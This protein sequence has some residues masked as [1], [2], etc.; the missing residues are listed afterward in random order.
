ME[1][2]THELIASSDELLWKQGCEALS[3]EHTDSACI[4]LIGLLGDKIWRKRE[5][6]AKF[7]IEWGPEVVPNL[8]KSLDETLPDHFYWSLF[9]L[10]HFDIPIGREKIL[11]NL[12]SPKAE[13]R[14]YA[15]RALSVCA[16]LQNAR[17]LYPLLS[18]RN[19]TIRKL[20][21]E[22]LFSF[23]KVILED[24]RQILL[25]NKDEPSHSV[26][27]LFAKLGQEKV[28]PE[29]IK[30]YQEGSFSM[31]YSVVSA[32]SEVELG[33]S[34]DFI[35]QSLSDSSWV[36]RKK[37]AEVLIQMGTR[38]FDRLSAW[39]GQGD[40]IM[41]RQI[42]DIIVSLL[43]ERALPL[44]QRLLGS[45][46]QEYRILAVESLSKLPGDSA[47]RLL[48]KSMNDQHRIVADYA[49]ECLAKKSNLNLD[50]LV[51]HLSTE[52]ENLRFLI[53]KTIGTIGGL[54]LNPIIQ[55]LENG[56]KDERMFLLG[57]LQRISPSEKLIDALIKM[58]GDSSWPIRSASA[59]CLKGYGE[60][61]VPGIVRV[62]NHESDDVQY[63][64]K[65]VLFSMGNVAVDS[66]TQILEHGSDPSLVPHLISALLSVDHPEAV[67]VVLR[68][69]QN[70]DDNRILFIIDG[71]QEITSREVINNILN[72]INHPDQR[73]VQWLS[74][75]LRK[76]KKPA[77][78]KIVLLGFGHSE[79]RCRLFV[80]DSVNYWEALTEPELKTIS[81]QLD[82]ERN[83]QNVIGLFRALGN[84]PVPNVIE[85]IKN[86][87]KSC[88]PNL[89][90]DLMVLL[91]ETERSQFFQ[92]LIETLRAR[93]EVIQPEDVDRVGKILG[94]LYKSKP[95]G[96]LQGL[97]S[98][99]MAYRL[100]S[101]VALEQIQGKRIA[102]ALMDSL[103]MNDDPTIINRA[104]KILAGY[105]FSED[106]RVK[107]AVTD[108]FLNLGK[109]IIDP[110]IEFARD[111][112]N[113]VDRKS[114]ID[115]IE[116]VGGVVDPQ[117][118]T[119]GE[120]KVVLSDSRL[121]EVLEKRKKALNELEKYDEIIRVS[122]TQD[123]T[124]MFTDVKGYTAFSSKA[125][126]SDVMIMLKQHDEILL[127]IITKHEGQVLKKIGDAF[128]VIFEK[129]H[130]SILS[131]IE[132]QRELKKY[133][134]DAP[135][136]RKLGVRVAINTGSVI[137]REGD[138]FG[139]AVNVT[140]RLEG[141]ADAEEIVISESTFLQVDQ[142]IFEITSFGEHK[143]KG[144]EKPVKAFKVAW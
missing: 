27:A 2:S 111:L 76:V 64:A 98:P 41:K 63:W 107:G 97:S 96:I 133:N 14:A 67:P 46:D 78:R 112:E 38:I 62:L 92:M 9:V 110:L 4:A 139:D 29:L 138:I 74:H 94:L 132:I 11:Q 19:W 8:V 22:K 114:L 15:I 34:V 115:L 129:P 128:L 85:A 45:P 17:V 61:A 32:L 137:R 48:I 84:Y 10:G 3:V 26:V 66:L 75:L 130:K 16:S 95:E 13:I 28:L 142:K 140:S 100:C 79:E 70:N 24:L 101:V 141:V 7:L 31:R 88:E 102:F 23:G 77:L 5:F 135:D 93:S 99:T 57:V 59:A 90:L 87:L 121:D 58:L 50:L 71:I 131:A 33:E 52:D 105:F 81:R 126:L 65:R 30:L 120:R 55:I 56:S 108:Y 43:G 117:M 144:I 40:S 39:F 127:P 49:S 44:I 143:L 104:V 83:P 109:G 118:F 82:I 123:L 86:Y 53:I 1:K 91:A 42:I 113:P 116:S 136:E 106:F 69:L 134:S 37:S 25:D 80:I 119:K 89:M 60:K 35:I 122:H 36:I 125:S 51:E 124:I 47:A 54:A 103:N 12:K 20:T 72:L 18:D 6:A 73:A 68:F 21:F